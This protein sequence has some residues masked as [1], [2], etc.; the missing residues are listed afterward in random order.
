MEKIVT[1]LWRPDSQT[2]QAYAD[3]LLLKAAPRLRELGAHKLK[4]CVEDDSVAAGSKL[5]MNPIGP[6]KAAMVGYWVE[7]AQDRGD[8]ERV[9]SEASASLASYLVVESKP[10]PN[11]QHPSTGNG[12]RTEGFSQVT[13]IT[14]KEGLTYDEFIRIWHTEQRPCATET[15]S[16][17]GYV[18]NEI[19]RRLVGE[20]PPWA[21]VVEELFPIG[22][23]EDPRVFYDAVGDEAKFRTNLKRMIDTVQT[24]LKMDATD[25]TAMSEHVFDA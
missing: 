21:A 17:F 5:R 9:L 3:T 12:A 8:L 4:V 22:A 7:C 11:L 14:P 19:V 18:R 13:C 23:L 2:P 1:L 10:T 15:Q 25:V 24:F 6:P 20:A 16:T